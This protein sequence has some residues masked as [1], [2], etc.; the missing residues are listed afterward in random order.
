MKRNGLTLTL[1]IAVLY[2]G[3]GLL[4]GST[5]MLHLLGDGNEDVMNVSIRAMNQPGMKSEGFAVGIRRE[6]APRGPGGHQ[7]GEDIFNLKIDLLKVTPTGIVLL[8]SDTIK[9]GNRVPVEYKFGFRPSESAEIISFTLRIFPT[10]IKEQPLEIQFRIN[11][12]QGDREVQEKDVTIG[13]NE[14]VIVELL[15]NK[16]TASTLSFRLTPMIK[17]LEKG[18]AGYLDKIYSAEKEF[19]EDPASHQ[20]AVDVKLLP[21]FAVDAAGNPVYDLKKEDIEFYVNGNPVDILHLRPYKFGKSDKDADTTGKS[22]DTLRKEPDRVIIIIVDQVFNSWAGIRR[23]K[24]ITA[25]LIK[26]GSDGDFFIVMT[27]TPAGGLRYIAGPS[28]HKKKLLAKID[29]LAQ[30]P[31]GRRKDL[32]STLGL[33]RVAERSDDDKLSDFET[34]SAPEREW[35]ESSESMQYKADVQRFSYVLSQFKY[36]LKTIEKPKIVFLVSRGVARDS[37]DEVFDL[38]NIEKQMTFDVFLFDYFKKIAKAVN[39]G[40]SLL[41]TINSQ[42]VVESIDRGKSGR[43]SLQEMAKTSGGEYFAGSDAIDLAGQVNRTLSAYYELVFKPETKRGEEMNVAVKSK[44]PGVT[45]HSVKYSEIERPY[46]KMEN[47]QKKLFALNVIH[48]GNWSR[49]VAK[50]E[51]GKSKTL[52]KQTRGDKRLITKRVH[53]PE[54]LK[55]REVDIFLIRKN[56]KTQKTRID[57]VVRK[58]TDTAE[59]RITGAK[60]EDLH[61]VIIEPKYVRCVHNRVR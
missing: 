25:N 38:K 27:N 7:K 60:G 41:Y 21:I 55:D 57:M 59:I 26:K 31:T 33:S 34:E 61:F 45:V 16:K 32:Y 2:V 47:I 28:N 19:F 40:G 42:K 24:E 6:L 17:T 51:K 46:H 39:E 13:E 22:K 12:F 35:S 48:G 10:I 30:L 37:F 56:P 50:I 18:A 3:H 9:A 14:S 11:L 54:G 5:A 43:T 36:A 4:F 58:V 29:T 8:K 52:Q 23:A 15:E 20:V 44:R 1:I 53:M 49:M